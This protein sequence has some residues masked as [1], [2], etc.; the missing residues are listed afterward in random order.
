MGA[1]TVDRVARYVELIADEAGTMEELSQRT[2]EQWT[3]EQICAAWDVPYSRILAWLAADPKRWGQYERAQRLLANVYAAETV[4][5]ADREGGGNH[6]HSAQK[7]KAR[8]WAAGKYD[9]PRFGEAIEHTG[10]GG[11]PL[12]VAD[13]EQFL[14][15]V[16]RSI[17]LVLARAAHAGERVVA[18]Q[19]AQVAVE[20]GE[21]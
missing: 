19:P 13:R 16:A 21:I 2:V 17:G 18:E 14:L 5:I 1:V 9:R 6:Q 11:E 3:L 10:A 4:M 8:Q 20:D 12:V 15:Q 7:I